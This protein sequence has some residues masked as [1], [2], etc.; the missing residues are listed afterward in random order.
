MIYLLFVMGA[1]LVTEAMVEMEAK[2]EVE[3]LVVM[4]VVEV[5]EWFE[6]DSR[7]D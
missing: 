2:V 1:A 5:V 7:T 4:G 3:V 6:E